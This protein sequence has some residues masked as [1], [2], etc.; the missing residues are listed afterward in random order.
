MKNMSTAM[1]TQTFSTPKFVVTPLEEA[2]RIP[3][4]FYI[5]Q[6][7]SP[8]AALMDM[9]WAIHTAPCNVAFWMPPKD[10]LPVNSSAVLDRAFATS[11]E[12][13]DSMHVTRARVSDSDNRAS[14]NKSLREYFKSASDMAP[15]HLKKDLLQWQSTTMRI[16][17][18]ME[19]S[20]Q[21]IG[22]RAT[23]A[24]GRTYKMNVLPGKDFHFD[25]RG[26]GERLQVP[27]SPL[28]RPLAYHTNLRMLWPQAGSGTLFIDN[29][30]FDHEAAARSLAVTNYGDIRYLKE[31]VPAYKMPTWGFALLTYKG[32]DHLPINHSRPWKTEDYNPDKRV[33][34][35]I[36]ASIKPDPAGHAHWLAK[37]GLSPS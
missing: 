13:L 33:L 29:D 22:L 31:A 23:L 30:D 7:A 20:A 3:A 26:F 28:G 15:L 17:G 21:N 34:W 19:S 16:L 5:S 2:D 1:L 24:T 9:Y 10:I 11:A 37:Q 6:E 27:E 25:G 36:M 8:R 4:N 32:W 14:R 12:T 35:D 18:P